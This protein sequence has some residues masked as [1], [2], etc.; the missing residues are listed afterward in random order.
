VRAEFAQIPKAAYGTER[1]VKQLDEATA[2][3]KLPDKH[4]ERLLSE[5]DEEQSGRE[6][7]IAQWQEQIDDWHADRVKTD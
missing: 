4:F 5:Y 7:G 3:G 6:K 1:L 2:A